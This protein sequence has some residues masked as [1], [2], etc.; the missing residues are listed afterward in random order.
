MDK[1]ES[2]AKRK[3][4]S[5]AVKDQDPATER[6]K[7]KRQKVDVTPAPV[8]PAPK[9]PTGSDSDSDDE[10]DPSTLVH[11]SLSTPKSSSS[12]SSKKIKYVPEDETS[13]QR[14]ARTIF[15]GNLSVQL[16][17]KRP[18]QK[19]LK[20]HILSFLPPTAK[21]ESIRMR[22]VPFSTPTSALP[23]PDTP[24]STKPKPSQHDL[25]R[26]S[27]WRQNKST[28]ED[29][30]AAKDTKKFLS[31]AQKKANRIHHA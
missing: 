17:Q 30:D 20:K 12:S 13:G 14:D 9:E 4:I 26:T 8:L 6:R 21:I 19:Q 29:E 24:A 28:R 5:E 25:N 11:E 16:A 1:S 23:D 31:P 10:G 22:S 27:A 2:K 7:H 15:I 3:S 18:L